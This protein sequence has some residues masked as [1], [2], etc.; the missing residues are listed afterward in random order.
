MP[1][2]SE[3]LPEIADFLTRVFGI[4][5][6]EDQ[7]IALLSTDYELVYEI[8]DWGGIDDVEFLMR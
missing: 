2:I 8:W 3:Y 7:A 6:D 5:I 4:E 1:D